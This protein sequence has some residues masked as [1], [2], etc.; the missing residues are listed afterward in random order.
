MSFYEKE[1]LLC[2]KCKSD[3]HSLFSLGPS[4]MSSIN[5]LTQTKFLSNEKEHKI[6]QDFQPMIETNNVD[7]IS[8]VKDYA[9]KE[10]YSMMDLLK[11]EQDILKVTQSIKCNIKQNIFKKITASQS[12]KCIKKENIVDVIKTS[13]SDQHVEKGKFV[14]T[15]SDSQN[16]QYNKKEN[17]IN[18]IKV[19]QND[20]PEKKET[21]ANTISARPN[22]QY[23][24][25]G[26]AINAIKS[27][28][29]YQHEKI[30]KFV[31]TISASQST[32]CI[33]KEYIINTIKA[34]QNDKH[35]KKEEYFKTAVANGN[36]EV[37]KCQNTLKINLTN[38]QYIQHDNNHNDDFTMP[39]SLSIQKNELLTKTPSRTKFPGYTCLMPN[40]I[41]SREIY[42]HEVNSSQE[43]NITDIDR[44]DMR[45]NQKNTYKDCLIQEILKPCTVNIVT[46]QQ[47]HSPFKTVN[48]NKFY[49]KNELKASKLKSNNKVPQTSII[50]YNNYKQPILQKLDEICTN[51]NISVATQIIEEDKCKDKQKL[52]VPIVE[53]LNTIAQKNL[54]TQNTCKSQLLPKIIEQLSNISSGITIIQQILIENN[55]LL[56]STVHN[57][58]NETMKSQVK[59]KLTES[60]TN[61]NPLMY[62]FNPFQ[63]KNLK[64]DSQKKI[65]FH[66]DTNL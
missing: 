54:T 7:E 39:S 25:K 48:E 24:K 46:N 12:T 16:T 57:Y 41:K 62:T 49:Y 26:T 2:C 66:L 1:E 65:K 28:Q 20:Q 40:V 51:Q 42:R 47:T 50:N 8:D 9:T 34:C 53:K 10:Y 15:I 58:Q 4:Y 30:E 44:N 37:E 45:F 55:D 14:Q 19:S 38:H 5:C 23:I 35:K 6:I 21:F 22:I 32:Q 61:V 43:T 63:P 59:R 64:K 13:Q 60:E 18:A 27:S 52:Q 36:D 31:N 3:L 17:A 11:I 56:V 29:N 33:E